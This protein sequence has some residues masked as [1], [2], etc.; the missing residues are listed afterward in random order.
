[1][2]F[3]SISNDRYWQ[4]SSNST[5]STTKGTYGVVYMGTPYNMDT[6]KKYSFACTRT[7]FQLTNT[8]LKGEPFVKIALYIQNL[9]VDILIFKKNNY[10]KINNKN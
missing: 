4:L 10:V 9:Q 5:L 7:Y 2:I 6:P 8:T 3:N 1:M